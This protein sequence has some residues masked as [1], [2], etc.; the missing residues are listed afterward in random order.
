MQSFA[1]GFKTRAF[2]GPLPDPRF[3]SVPEVPPPTLTLLNIPES[4][5]DVALAEAYARGTLLSGWLTNTPANIGTTE[6][7]AAAAQYVAGLYDTMEATVLEREDAEALGMGAYL[8]V[9]QVRSMHACMHISA[10]WNEDQVVFVV[11]L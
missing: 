2:A 11:D 7:M 5:E 8:S 3:A 1:Y 6:Y 10:E 4:P 9:T